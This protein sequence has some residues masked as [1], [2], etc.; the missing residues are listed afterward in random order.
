MI[1]FA[2][3]DKG[4]TGRS[5]TSCN[6]GY[7]LSSRG[8][9]VAYLDFDFGSPTAGALFE[10]G[11]YERGI[12]PEIDRDSGAGQGV[13]LHAYLLGTGGAPA[14]INVRDRTDRE[15]VRR[16]RGRGG[17]LVLFPGDQGGGEFDRRW[18]PEVVE[19]CVR[20]LHTVD[21]EFD[22][23]IVDLS[24]GRSIAL[25][26]VLNATAQ[27]V[28]AARTVRW[29]VFHRWTRQHVYA[30]S[31][32]V[33]GRHGLL[34][35][36]ERAGH[37]HDE[38]LSNIRFVR[39]AVPQVDRIRGGPAPQAS[40]LHQQDRILNELAGELRIGASSLLGTIPVEPMLQWREQLILDV[41][42]QKSIANRATVEAFDHL[43]DRL[44]DPR[45]WVP[46]N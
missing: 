10:L 27:G 12:A 25:D 37:D 30:A 34:E 32:L 31:G 13:G 33:Y 3:S 19:R 4:G 1:V 42:V 46:L 9:R 18:D 26:I 40:W 20:L 38:L 11:G 6:L 36:G 2:T 44:L 35:C 7:R 8:K 43:G 39:T 24:A 14:R 17:Q 16:R 41:D 21:K 45:T 22:L 15:D 5:V 23:S 28:L 29:L